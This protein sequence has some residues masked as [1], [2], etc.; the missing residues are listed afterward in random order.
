MPVFQKDTPINSG[1]KAPVQLLVF[2][3]QGEEY[4]LPLTEIQEIVPTP[5]I[6]PV[7][8]MTAAVKGV[9][10][11][12]GRVVTMLDLETHFAISKTTETKPY[13]IVAEHN[14]ELFGLLVHSAEEVLRIDGSEQKD[15]PEVLRSHPSADALKGVIVHT[16]AIKGKEA[17]QKT[18]Q[19]ERIILALD[20]PK[21]LS[22]F[23]STK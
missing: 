3:L 2:S 1:A 12:R 23:S 6:T 15:T 20:L 13:A 5:E 8:N 4:A 9:A 19:T 21:I 7:P 11:L 16:S 14:G 22:H 10:N 17:G 18:A